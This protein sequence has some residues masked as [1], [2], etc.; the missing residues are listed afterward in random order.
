MRTNVQRPA[1]EEP[2]KAVA[3]NGVRTVVAVA[4][5]AAVMHHYR[6]LIYSK[7]LHR[8][9]QHIGVTA[10]PTKTFDRNITNR[11]KRRTEEMTLK[12]YIYTKSRRAQYYL[13]L[14]NKIA[15]SN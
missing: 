10:F 4:V 15:E 7:R 5:A 12:I 13:D 1:I 6:D 9:P 8:L 11:R 2:S 3:R 14:S